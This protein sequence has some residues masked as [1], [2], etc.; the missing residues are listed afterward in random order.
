MFGKHRVCL[1]LTFDVLVGSKSPRK[2]KKK[3]EL[4]LQNFF[5][6]RMSHSVLNGQKID[7]LVECHLRS[8]FANHSKACTQSAF[9][10]EINFTKNFVKL[11]SRNK[12]LHIFRK[13][14][15][16]RI[17]RK[18]EKW[19]VIV[20]LCLFICFNIY[21]WCDLYMVYEGEVE[22]AKILGALKVSD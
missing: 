9:F 3:K 11:F 2:K 7:T 5:R 1:L 12:V 4:F 13:E 18:I 19:S 8:A 17:I 6:N 22:N 21:Y 16:E 10:R 15:G 20:Y 14:F